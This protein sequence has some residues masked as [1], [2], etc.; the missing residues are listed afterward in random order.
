MRENF[1][2]LMKSVNRV[3]Y[4]FEEIQKSLGDKGKLG[5][6]LYMLDDDQAHTQKQLSKDW[7]IPRSTLNAAVKIAQ[8]EGYIE[9]QK[10]PNTR[11]EL[12]IVLTDKGR[13]EAKNILTPYVEME[14]KALKETSEKYS[15]HFVEVMDY[16]SKQLELE[17]DGGI[18]KLSNA[19]SEN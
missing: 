11:R 2:S 1:R 12:V 6:L 17:V 19:N 3:I 10:V 9:L 4:V 15:A 13:N 16:F 14:D 8:E 5:W 7:M 18:R